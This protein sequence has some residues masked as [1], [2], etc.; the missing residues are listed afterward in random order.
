MTLAEQ[1]A[2]HQRKIEQA[3]TRRLKRLKDPD[4]KAAVIAMS[5][6]RLEEGEP[7]YGDSLFRREYKDLFVA[8]MEEDADAILYCLGRMYQGWT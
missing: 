1:L 2:Y 6:K 8:E 3:Y 7:L 4:Y 5:L